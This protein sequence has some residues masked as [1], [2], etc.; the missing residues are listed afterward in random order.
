MLLQGGD[1][2]ISFGCTSY[3]EKDFVVYQRLYDI[4]NITV[5]SDQDT[6]GLFD[7]ESQ[8]GVNCIS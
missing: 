5:I 3:E 4:T 7:I 1:Y 6:V 2:L 8:V